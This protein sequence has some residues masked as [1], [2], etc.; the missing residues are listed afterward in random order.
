MPS[1][2]MSGKSLNLANIKNQM[3]NDQKKS[4][5][6]YGTSTSYK[7]YRF[8]PILFIRTC[9]YETI[10]RPWFIYD[11]RQREKMKTNWEREREIAVEWRWWMYVSM[12]VL[13]TDDAL[14][15]MLTFPAL[16]YEW[17]IHNAMSNTHFTNHNSHFTFHLILNPSN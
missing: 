16:K 17:S 6:S 11:L 5:L 4:Y 2:L 15:E 14:L 1:H 3:N 13:Q 8:I 7:F 10:R 9:V 12:Y